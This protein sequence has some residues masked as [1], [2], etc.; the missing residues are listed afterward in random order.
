MNDHIQNHILFIIFI[1]KYQKYFS[2]FVFKIN[3][4]YCQCDNGYEGTLCESEVDEC[5]A[6][7]PCI[8][9]KCFDRIGTYISI[10]NDPTLFVSG[11]LLR[12]SNM[13]LQ[14][15]FYQSKIPKVSVS[16]NAKYILTNSLNKKFLLYEPLRGIILR[17]KNHQN[18]K[19]YENRDLKLLKGKEG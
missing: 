7:T 12:F 2:H 9:G 4:F 3:N 1:T 8:H 6:Y 19:K 18:K 14:I 5:A 16:L 15:L 13:S 11:T 10:V 17:N